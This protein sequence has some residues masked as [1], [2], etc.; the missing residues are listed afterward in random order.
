MHQSC[1]TED[2]NLKPEKEMHAYL[3]PP[4]K[5]ANY[6]LNTTDKMYRSSVFNMSFCIWCDLIKIKGKAI[7]SLKQK[8]KCR[9][10]F[11]A[12][13]KQRTAAKH[14]QTKSGMR[15]GNNQSSNITKVT[16]KAIRIRD[17]NIKSFC[18][19]WNLSTVVTYTQ[20]LVKTV[21]YQYDNIYSVV[22]LI[23]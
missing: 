16:N 1:I 18:W 14:I 2:I 11:I 3:I 13:F 20:T 21:T 17:S 19:P 8:L 15:H 23:F 10:H 9:L 5:N 22:L 12:L 4:V 7:R 6:L